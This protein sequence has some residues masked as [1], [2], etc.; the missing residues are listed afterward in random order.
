MIIG[1]VAWLWA[2]AAFIVVFI[3]IVE[4]LVVLRS[5][6]VSSEATSPTQATSVS[7]TPQSTAQAQPSPKTKKVS[8]MAYAYKRKFATEDFI[9][10]IVDENKIDEAVKKFNQIFL[11]P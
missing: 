5:P 3:L 7:T 11:A 8:T 10:K 1:A 2:I 6:G 4:Y 9:Q